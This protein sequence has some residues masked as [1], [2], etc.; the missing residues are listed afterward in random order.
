MA[1]N[2]RRTNIFHAISGVA[3]ETL[4]LIKGL[5]PYMV[6]TTKLTDAMKVNAF[7]EAGD[8]TYFLTVAAKMLKV[9]VPGSGKKTKLKGMTRSEA[10]VQMAGMASDMFDLVKKNFYGPVLTQQAV[11]RTKKVWK[12]DGSGQRTAEFDTVTETV[13]QA[14]PDLEATELKFQQRENEIA[15]ILGK[16]IELFW[17]FCYDTFEVPPANIM[18]GNIAKL[19][20]RY[21][22]NFFDLSEADDKQPEAETTAM[23]AAALAIPVIKVKKAALKKTPVPA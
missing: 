3:A 21:G 15:A 17:A 22:K 9:P 14:M 4:E 5:G 8:L 10:I 20:K 12:L 19:E 18:V 2:T 16:Y 13:Q 11:K 6:G 1:R 7:E 23:T